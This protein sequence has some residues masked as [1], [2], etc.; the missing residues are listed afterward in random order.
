MVISKFMYWTGSIC[1]I[2][3][4]IEKSDDDFR[5]SVND[6]PMSVEDLQLSVAV[7]QFSIKQIPTVS[8]R[9]LAVGRSASSRK[10]GTDSRMRA[11]TDC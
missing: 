2:S 9:G 3:G 5:R 11:T 4:Y 7:L 8:E 10:T 6:L 1:C